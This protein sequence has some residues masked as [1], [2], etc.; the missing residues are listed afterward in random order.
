[1][2]PT[3]QGCSPG[4]WHT[5][6]TGGPA[7]RTTVCTLVASTPG[8]C[9]PAPL[10]ALH[11]PSLSVGTCQA[12]AHTPALRPSWAS[13]T[14]H[15]GGHPGPPV[16]RLGLALEVGTQPGPTRGLVQPSL[17][18]TGPSL[19]LHSPPPSVPDASPLRS[20]SLG[21]LPLV[22][23]PPPPRSFPRFLLPAELLEGVGSGA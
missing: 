3:S 17:L 2:A 6:A 15:T 14:G 8:P 10:G 23:R 16:V 4:T 5:R 20:P 12:A 1:M 13:D 7:A 22:P 18:C 11:Q 19:H 21:T 9:P